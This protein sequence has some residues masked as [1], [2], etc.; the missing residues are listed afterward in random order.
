MSRFLI[1]QGAV[2]KRN[3]IYVLVLLISFTF[4]SCDGKSTITFTQSTSGSIPARWEYEY[5]PDGYIS[6]IKMDETLS[7]KI[8]SKIFSGFSGSG[9][10]Y[11]YKFKS[12]KPGEV[13]LCWVRYEPI[14]WIN[15]HESYAVDYTINEDLEI[16]QVGE[17]RPI[18]EIEKYD[19]LLFEQFSDES[20]LSLDWAL[21]NY[22]NITCSATSNYE[23]R[24]IEVTVHGWNSKN[25]DDVQKIIYDYLDNKFQNL[26]EVMH[27][28]KINIVFE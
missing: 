3:I 10:S 20:H 26:I 15:I 6:L 13:T 23:T 4:S 18:Y 2:L 17:K 14:N 5:I 28:T 22:K 9:R 1:N 21:K 24:T 11:Y 16:L 19:K 12:E 27:D 25:K 8:Y 7:S